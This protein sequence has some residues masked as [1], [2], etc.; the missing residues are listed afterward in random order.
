MGGTSV[1]VKVNLKAA[2]ARFDA[3]AQADAT[4]ALARQVESDMRPYVKRDTGLLEGSAALDSD[5]RGGHI[6]YS[7]TSRGS[8]YAGYA[9]D[10]SNVAATDRN[11]KATSHWFEAAKKACGAK[12]KGTAAKRFGEGR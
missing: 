3:K 11:P 5:F 12:W 9:Y 10:D 7:A 1:S 8:E 4:E 6:K 2:K